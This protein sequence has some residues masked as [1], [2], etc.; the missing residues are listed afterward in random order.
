MQYLNMQRLALLDA[1]IQVD[2]AS[3]GKPSSCPPGKL[4]MSNSH[5][6]PHNSFCSEAIQIGLHGE[7]NEMF[8]GLCDLV[9]LGLILPCICQNSC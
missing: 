7:E 9:G 6:N 5:R 8:C 1:M 2:S 4:K 3:L